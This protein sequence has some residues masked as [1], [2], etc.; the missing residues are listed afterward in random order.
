ML[1][2]DAMVIALAAA[3]TRLNLYVLTTR[4]LHWNVS[5]NVASLLNSTDAEPR[6]PVLETEKYGGRGEALSV[7]REGED[8]AS[9]DMASASQVERIMILSG[10]E[11]SFR[12]ISTWSSGS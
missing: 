11:C 1:T 8:E 5:S 7:K 12:G 9:S 10:S 4:S 3:F 6:D 2:F